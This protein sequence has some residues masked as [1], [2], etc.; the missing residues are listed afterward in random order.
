MSDAPR[1][2][3]PLDRLFDLER[4]KRWVHACLDAAAQLLDAGEGGKVAGPIA[5]ELLRT[6]LEALEEREVTE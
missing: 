5:M 4:T 2:R 1:G 6:S 3:R